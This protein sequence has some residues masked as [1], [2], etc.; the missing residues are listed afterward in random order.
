MFI[1]NVKEFCIFLKSNEKLTKCSSRGLIKSEQ[2]CMNAPSYK[3]TK[4]GLE[5]GEIGYSESNQVA[6][7]ES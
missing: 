7:S 1:C 6:L 5:Q 4:D 3:G 2:H